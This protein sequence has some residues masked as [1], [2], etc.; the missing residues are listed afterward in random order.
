MCA[1]KG[2][3]FAQGR[4]FYFALLFAYMPLPFLPFWHMYSL[5]IQLVRIFAYTSEVCSF[6]KFSI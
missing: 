5:K 4:L 3:E 6:L 2:Q 1:N